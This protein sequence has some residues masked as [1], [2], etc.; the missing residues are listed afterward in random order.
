MVCPLQEAVFS[1][2]NR[3]L[4]FLLAFYPMGL[5]IFQAMSWILLMNKHCL[6]HTVIA[7]VKA[8][9][10]MSRWTGERGHIVWATWHLKIQNLL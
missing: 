6:D 3:C 1:I 10:G 9:K 7:V 8:L 4:D 5:V 2:Q